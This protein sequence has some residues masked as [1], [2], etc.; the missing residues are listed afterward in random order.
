M[1]S[2]TLRPILIGMMVIMMMFL[3]LGR[4]RNVT[5][6]NAE[7][8]I[9]YALRIATQDA[10]VAMI[11]KN[12]MMDGIN[13]DTGNLAV[14]LDDADKRFL[15]SFNMNIGAAI[16]PVTIT[17]MN[18]PVSGY[19]GY[20]YVFGRLSNGTETFPYA[21]SYAKDGVVYEFTMGDAV[22]ETNAATGEIEVSS[23]SNYPEEFFLADT[24]NEDFRTITIM[25]S[26]SDFFTM[27]TSDPS[28]LMMVNSGSGLTF[29][30]G[31]VD[32][33]NHDPSQLVE[34]ASVIDGPGYFAVVDFFDAQLD[35][36]VRTFTFGGAEYISDFS[37]NE[38]TLIPISLTLTTQS[39]RS[40]IPSHI[41]LPDNLKYVNDGYVS[42]PASYVGDITLLYELSFSTT[43]N[44]SFIVSDDRAVL[45]HSNCGATTESSGVFK[46]RTPDT[47]LV[48]LYV[49]K[50][51]SAEEVSKNILRNTVEVT[52]KQGAE[53]LGSG[54]ATI[55][56]MIIRESD[57]DSIDKVTV[58]LPKK[59]EL[60]EG[61]ST[62]NLKFP[63]SRGS[64]V[65]PSQ[66]S[67]TLL[68]KIELNGNANT[69]FR[70]KGDFGEILYENSS[71]YLSGNEIT[72]KINSDG[73]SLI[74]VTRTVTAEDVVSKVLSY[75]LK[76]GGVTDLDSQLESCMCNTFVTVN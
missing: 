6:D 71:A 69:S 60:P 49:I 53:T 24:S 12:H 52:V 66:G 23:L 45:V 72:G 47:G 31:G 14:K 68:Y 64:L 61:V 10:T 39:D 29:Q 20:R 26:I 41:E 34:F 59:S 48:T 56:D 70:L 1:I 30:L 58:S 17:S 73:V 63:P 11:D 18:L 38:T 33:T 9:A 74:Y 37:S 16:K 3:T 15:Q 76:Y 4:V 35:G 67:I 36:Q 5:N 2:R 62:D 55:A 19:V 51:Y 28:N 27:F 65:I 40:Q 54:T 57:A 43:P 25:Q 8:E 75:E 7:D 46:G 32:F 21:Y 13:A 50:T 22:Y 44:T 42:V